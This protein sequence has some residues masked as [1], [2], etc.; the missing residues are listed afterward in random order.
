MN[1]IQIIDSYQDKGILQMMWSGNISLIMIHT[2]LS[3]LNRMLQTQSTS[4]NLVITVDASTCLPQHIQPDDLPTLQSVNLRGWMV[5][6]SNR[7]LNRTLT[8]MMN[9]VAPRHNRDL[10]PQ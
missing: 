1:R 10:L 4:V 6:G 9:Y 7:A 5:V 2:A 3:E 8:D